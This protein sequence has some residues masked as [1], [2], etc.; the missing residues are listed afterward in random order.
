MLVTIKSVEQWGKVASSVRKSQKLDQQS[1]G[2]FSGSSI[3]TIGAFEKG[4]GSMSVGRVFALMKALGLEV[5][6]DIALPESD[7][8]AKQKLISQI[9]LLES[10]Y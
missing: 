10:N 7:D 4:S 9:Q 5:K 2:G 8:K 6:I 3:N 1:A